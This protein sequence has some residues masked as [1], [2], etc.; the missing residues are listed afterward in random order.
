[1]V[2]TMEEP[3]DRRISVRRKIIRDA[4]LIF[5]GIILITVCF[6]LLGVAQSYDKKDT[7]GDCD[8]CDSKKHANA[9]RVF[10]SICFLL[11]FI[12]MTIS[13]WHLRSLK[14]AQGQN[15]R[16]MEQQRLMGNHEESE[17]IRTRNRYR[18]RRNI[19]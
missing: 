12:L 16:L 8:Y 10:A 14:R 15:R 5:I 19:D 11:G 4:I 7:R 17:M 3:D 9:F 6:V 13:S 1:M 18:R 2:Y